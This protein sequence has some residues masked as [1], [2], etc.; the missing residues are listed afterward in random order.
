M[1]TALLTIALALAV[2]PLYSGQVPRKAAELSVVQPN[3]TTHLLSQYKG[4]VI[5]IEFMFTTCPHCQTS[6]QLLTKLQNEYGPRGFQVLAVAFNPMAK[7]LVP[8]FV[9]DF[10]VNF[11]IGYAERDPVTS[12]LQHPDSEQ[13]TVPQIVFVDRK[14]VV[15]GQS[16]PMGDTHTASESFLRKNIEQLLAEPAGGAPAKVKSAAAS[17]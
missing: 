8:D 2:S 16:L 10:K 3:G 14:G 12:F 6:A 13:L 11:P 1:R 17:K 4:K 5:V 9:R 7:M 15:R